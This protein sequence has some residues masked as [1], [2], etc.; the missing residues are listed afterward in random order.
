MHTSYLSFFLHKSSSQSQPESSSVVVVLTWFAMLLW[1]DV[2]DEHE[3]IKSPSQSQSESSSVVVV[4]KDSPAASVAVQ[5]AREYLDKNQ[6]AKV[7]KRM[8][9]I[10]LN[11]RISKQKRAVKSWILLGEKHALYT[12]QP[13]PSLH[14][15]IECLPNKSNPCPLKS[16]WISC[17]ISTCSRTFA[18]LKLQQFCASYVLSNPNF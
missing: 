4:E 14:L 7:E 10:F 1:L 16:F 6:G 3:I 18:Y 15:L 17:N 2:H 12:V 11:Y 5:A 9:W 8:S 13:L